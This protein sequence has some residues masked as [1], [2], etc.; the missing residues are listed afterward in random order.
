MRPP[1]GRSALAC[2]VVGVLPTIATGSCSL[3]FTATALADD[4]GGAFTP[5]PA[6]FVLHLYHAPANV[7]PVE[8]DTKS[9]PITL[10]S[11]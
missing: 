6:S 10:T 11:P 1:G 7:T 4:V 2:R 8:Y 5:G 9:I 3:R